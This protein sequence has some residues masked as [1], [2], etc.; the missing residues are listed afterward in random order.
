MH[1]LLEALE[2][3]IV[4][5][6]KRQKWVERSD[7]KWIAA[8]L[9]RSTS[10]LELLHIL[11]N[12][13]NRDLRVYAGASIVHWPAVMCT[14]GLFQIFAAHWVLADD[15]CLADLILDE[16]FFLGLLLIDKLSANLPISVTN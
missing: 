2:I 5:P 11:S 12:V 14:T 10:N 8:K 16:L 13:L 7:V 1:P 3:L 9:K 15:L 4:A 6:W